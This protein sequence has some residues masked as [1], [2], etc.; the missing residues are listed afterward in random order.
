MSLGGVGRLVHAFAVAFAGVEVDEEVGG[1]PTAG[2]VVI[3]GRLFVF[4]LI[5]RPARSG[6]IGIL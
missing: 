5:P 4:G 3:V 2:V 6:S 1:I